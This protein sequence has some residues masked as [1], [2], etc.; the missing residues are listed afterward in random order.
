MLVLVEIHCRSRVGDI[1]FIFVSNTLLILV[2][3]DDTG[4]DRHGLV[5]IGE[6]DICTV[7]T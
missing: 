1:S 2:L 4:Y 6:R 5:Q 7:E 3:K